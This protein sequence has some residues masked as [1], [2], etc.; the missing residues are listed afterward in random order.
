MAADAL[1]AAGGGPVAMVAVSTAGDRDRRRPFAEIGGRGIFTKELEEA[2]LDGRIDVAA[3]SAKDLT[4]E[5]VPG[6][7]L[8][9]ALP[10][11]DPRDAWCGPHA[12]LDEVPEGATVGTASIRRRS[13][14]LAVRPDL[15]IEP[16]RGNVDTRLRR[17]LERGY[18]GVVLAA[19]GLDRL[20]M[21]EEIGFRFDPEVLLPEA[22]QGIVALQCRS[23]DAADV[24]PCGD[25][26]ALRL[27]LAERAA[28]RVL[29][30]GCRTPVAAH[31]TIG[32][33]GSISLR[34]WV[35]TPDGARVATAAGEGDDAEALGAR[36]ARA[37]L[38]SA[39]AQLLSEARG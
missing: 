4:T 1:R 25:A 22:G 23:A 24:A 13:Q 35:G 5:D 31:G 15:R 16:V 36:V 8:A 39:G 32:T 29:E 10:R 14:L 28:A 21:A 3:H 12:A 27:L 38:A 37:L 34:A 6:L 2:L 26:G 20:G 7:A 11:A 18:A 30:G 17:R 19:C 33:G 9:A